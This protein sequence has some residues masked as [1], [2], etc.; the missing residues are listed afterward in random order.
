M[1]K[2]VII[3]IIAL[4]VGALS[5]VTV[6]NYLHMQDQIRS[7]KYQVEQGS[8]TSGQ[9]VQA[10]PSQL[11]TVE[12]KG[13]PAGGP[14][15]SSDIYSQRNYELEIQESKALI[16]DLSSQNKKLLKEKLA[17]EKKLASVTA[18]FARS[19]AEL[20]SFKATNEKG[21]FAKVSNNTTSLT[22]PVE[23]EVLDVN[24]DLNIVIL[25][26]GSQQGMQLGVLFS[27]IR[28]EDVI[29]KIKVIEVRETFTGT[30]IIEKL[31]GWPISGDRV[32]LWK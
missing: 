23:A 30:R 9:I 4:A 17:I 25:N 28:G 32:I 16:S 8:T 10:S 19:K 22:Q 7:L 6:V 29:A 21:I 14:T 13:V 1:G 15:Y 18:S 12:Q 31:R 26:K 20:D 24:P 5:A 2:Q 3:F 27:V 11:E